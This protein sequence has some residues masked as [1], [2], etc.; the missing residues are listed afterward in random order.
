MPFRD[1]CLSLDMPVV[2]VVLLQLAESPLLVSS[3]VSEAG[4]LST[5]A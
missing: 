5:G 1:I 4:R 2:P 3:V